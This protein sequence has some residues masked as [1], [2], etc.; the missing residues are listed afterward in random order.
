[1]ISK[2]TLIDMVKK[3]LSEEISLHEL[4]DHYLGYYPVLFDGRSL[5]L[6]EII[7]EIE[8]SIVEM[9]NDRLSDGEFKSNLRDF[10]I[11]LHIGDHEVMEV[12]EEPIDMTSSSDFDEVQT[13]DDVEILNSNDDITVF[14]AAN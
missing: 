11:E 14:K 10:L 1:M 2:T 4:R 7:D 8:L 13:N 3:Y 6:E 12:S 9:D 5:L